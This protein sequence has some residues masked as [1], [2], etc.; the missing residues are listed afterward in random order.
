M[1]PPWTLARLHGW[2]LYCGSVILLFGLRWTNGSSGGSEVNRREELVEEDWGLATLMALGSNAAL[3]VGYG[4]TYVNSWPGSLTVWTLVEE[5]I[6][7]GA[8]GLLVYWKIIG[9]T[10]SF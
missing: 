9:R 3:W 6:L 2:Y 1:F 4:L 10:Q 8:A 7:G 5:A